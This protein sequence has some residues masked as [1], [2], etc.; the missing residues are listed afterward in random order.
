M[1][2]KNLVFYVFTE[3][4]SFSSRARNKLQTRFS[5][6]FIGRINENVIKNVY[7]DLFIG[8]STSN[9]NKIFVRMYYMKVMSVMFKTDVSRT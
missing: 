5:K 4:N 2:E 3:K 6:S 7:D 8:K 9:K 1:Q